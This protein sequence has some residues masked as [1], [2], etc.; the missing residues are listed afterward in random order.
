LRSGHRDATIKVV[1]IPDPTRLVRA[2][3]AREQLAPAGVATLVNHCFKQFGKVR[4]GCPGPAMTPAPTLSA[5]ARLAKRSGASPPGRE[6]LLGNH[7]L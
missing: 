6:F 3:K 5:V 4:E 7:A 2:R 1:L